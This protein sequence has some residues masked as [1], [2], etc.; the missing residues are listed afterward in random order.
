MYLQQITTSPPRRHH[1]ATTR[2]PYPIPPV[3]T[4]P[5][6]TL[7][8]F[9]RMCPMC[10]VPMMVDDDSPGPRQ[11]PQRG[12]PKHQPPP[13]PPDASDLPT[14][15]WVPELEN[16]KHYMLSHVLSTRDMNNV[17]MTVVARATPAW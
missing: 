16:L 1:V 3:T 13:P 17:F 14:C 12:E 2:A 5:Y 10:D 6:A 11:S 4:P 8:L 9:D 15:V 7:P